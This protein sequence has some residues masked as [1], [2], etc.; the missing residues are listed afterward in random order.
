MNNVI[1]ISGMPVSGKSTTI[2][3]IIKTLM[4]KGYNQD[5]IHIVSTGKEFR[6]YFN[7]IVDLIKNPNDMKS[8]VEK[9]NDSKLKELLNNQTFRQKLIQTIIQIRKNGYDLQNFTIE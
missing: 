6:K 2:D 9:C 5:Q 4:K 3:E 1:S 8:V 7:F